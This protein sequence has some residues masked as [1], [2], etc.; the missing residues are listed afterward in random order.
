MM[1]MMMI[2]ENVNPAQRVYGSR[3][4]ASQAESYQ[5]DRS[6]AGKEDSLVQQQAVQTEGVAE[7]K[8]EETD[9]TIREACE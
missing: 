2:I 7:R 3:P 1:M 6:C 4:S 5:E 8:S 9:V